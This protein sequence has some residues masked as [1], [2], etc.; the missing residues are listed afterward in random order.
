MTV[1][2][3]FIIEKNYINGEWIHA[4]D[5]ATITIHNPA[6]NEILGI[7]PDATSE[8]TEAAILA[9]H[10]AQSG[11][12]ALDAWQRSKLLRKLYDL[13]VAHKDALAEIMTLENGKPLSESKA[14]IDYAAS[15]IDWFA[16]EAKRAYG[17]II[18]A[19]VKNREI[20]IIKQPIGVV[21]IITPWNFPSA[22]LTRKIGAAF[23]A[24]CTVIVKPDHRTPY[25][26]L[27]LAKLA[28]EAGFPKGV[29]NIITGD[30][31]MIGKIFTTHELVKKITFTGSTRVGKI[32]MEQSS[33]TLKRMSL[34]LG[35]NAPFIICEDADLDLAL[36]QIMIAKMRNTGQSC[37]AANRIFISDKIQEK[38]I[39]KLLPKVNVLQQGKDYGPMIDQTAVEKLEHLVN[40]AIQKGAHL[41]HGGETPKQGSNFYLPTIL[42]NV[43]QN[44]ECEQVEIFGPVFAISSFENDQE[45]LARSNATNVGL[46]SYV[47]T[48]DIKRADYYTTGLQYGMVG[49]NTGLISFAGAPFGG[50]KESGFHRE[51]GSEG[52]EAY[53]ET[54][55]IAVQN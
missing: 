54:K 44:A 19:A 36:E 4:Q 37:V 20:K 17:R 11:W 31:T 50:Y 2:K 49:M 1:S 25:S 40:D 8:Q 45:A 16:D 43:P 38:F 15:F 18:P 53:L 9:A 55:Y 35:G 6:N 13:M 39:E 14:E 27:A 26:A 22:M 32:L 48:K 33:S 12:A 21:G 23:A 46:A 24:G 28:E 29:F 51:G 52:L 41:A 7:V 10:Q 34:E 42:T 47:F 3:Q 5:K 30:A